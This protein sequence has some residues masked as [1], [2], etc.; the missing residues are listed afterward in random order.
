MCISRMMKPD[1]K[2]KIKENVTAYEKFLLLTGK[3]DTA[4]I[5]MVTKYGSKCKDS[6]SIDG[7]M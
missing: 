5:A 6:A 4:V 1:N 3:R 7:L 2:S